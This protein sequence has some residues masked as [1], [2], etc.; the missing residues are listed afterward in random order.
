MSNEK[1]G[2]WGRHYSVSRYPL[3]AEVL[4]N[5]LALV[6]VL[7]IDESTFHGT[8]KQRCWFLSFAT[9]WRNGS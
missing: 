1:A 7:I 5:R 9:A 8:F 2:D 3:W 6:V 4:G